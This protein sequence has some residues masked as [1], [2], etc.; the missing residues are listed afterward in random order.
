MR[1]PNLLIIAAA[2]LACTTL[3]SGEGS[4]G[5]ALIVTPERAAPGDTITLVLR[6]DS[7]DELGYNLCTSSLHRR[8]GEGAWDPIA[9]ERVCTLE[10]R[11]LSPRQRATLRLDLP[12]N[13]APGTYRF[14]TAVE[15]LE[16]SVRQTVTSE[17]FTL[18]T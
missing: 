9:S 16:L 15:R 7:Q 1:F 18:E 17:P 6:N 11:S 2:L 4:N 5:V 3:G 12:Q 13:L 8:T 10:L 14:E